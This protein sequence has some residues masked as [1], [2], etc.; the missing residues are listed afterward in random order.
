VPCSTGIATIG[1]GNSVD[2]IKIDG[3][4]MIGAP[5]V[6]A[7]SAS[8]TATAI[9]TA[10]NIFQS[11]Y[12]AEA[13]SSTVLFH[14]QGTGCNSYHTNAIAVTAT[15][16]TPT[17][18]NAPRSQSLTRATYAVTG[19]VF[20]GHEGDNTMK[21]ARITYPYDSAGTVGEPVP[22]RWIPDNIA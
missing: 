10:S 5:I 22:S 16:F 3:V 17:T 20:S 15:G 11:A 12:L 2:T 4:D 13:R 18:V 6:Y 21:V 1:I 19:Q 9:A 7:T 14:P 8:A